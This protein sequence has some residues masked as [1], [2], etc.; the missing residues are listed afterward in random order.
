MRQGYLLFTSK[1]KHFIH[2][3]G[4]QVLDV[5]PF[6]LLLKRQEPE[7]KNR[8]ELVSHDGMF[9]ACAFCKRRFLEVETFQKCT[10]QQYLTYDLVSMAVYYSI[11]EVT[12]HSSVL[13]DH[14]MSLSQGLILPPATQ[15]NAYSKFSCLLY[16]ENRK[17][18]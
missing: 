16:R 3:C 2:I 12:F 4:A 14:A 17:D 8:R 6:K 11:T 15:L 18:T 13:S 5:F 9:A 10:F 1:R 7:P